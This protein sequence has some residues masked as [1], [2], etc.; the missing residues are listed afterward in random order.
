[1]MEMHRRTLARYGHPDIA[2]WAGEPHGAG[3]EWLLDYIESNV[4][5]GTRFAAGETVQVGWV[6]VMM[7]EA[8]PGL[9][10]VM[11]PDFASMP[12]AWVPGAGNT[13]RFLT[14]Q[15]QVCRQAGLDSDHA[16]MLHP[17]AISPGFLANPPAFRLSRES[18][19]GKLAGWQ[20]RARGDADGESALCS[21]YQVACSVPAI[22]PFMGLPPGAIVDVREDAI[23]IA[24]DG[25]TVSSRD[26]D[27][28]RR[29]LQSAFLRRG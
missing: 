16:S 14:I 8:E 26:N 23:E 29:L 17:A 25:R 1:M 11:E 9:L 3:A 6:T 15:Q 7:E 13:L 19:Y 5:A 28:L 12:V 21:L 18:D 22:I 20:C 27:F 24:A 2:V 4:A 10:E